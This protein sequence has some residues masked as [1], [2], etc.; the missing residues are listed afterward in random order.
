VIES[1]VRHT[2]WFS[3]GSDLGDLNNDGLMD[4][5]AADM[6]ASTHYRDKMMMGNMEDSGW[7]LDLAE[8]RQYMRNAVYVNSGADQM[9]E[10][11]FQSG[12]SSS[13]WTWSPRLEDFDNDGRVDVFATNGILRDAMNSDLSKFATTSFQPGSPEWAQF[14]AKQPMHKEA[15]QAFKNLG[16]L[17]FKQVASEWGLDRSG[18]S[19]GAATADF[20]NDGDLDLV[21]NNADTAVSLYENR[22]ATGHSV[23]VRLRGSK[24]NRFGIGATVHVEAGGQ[25]HTRYLTLSRGWLSACEPTLHVGLGAAAKI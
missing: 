13:D 17:K 2:P 18:V 10:V 8:P 20:D 5:F 11:A 15:N 25:Q 9:M 22:S 21:I 12:L 14:W 16:D 6:S 4:F 24:S 23:R 3:M 19:F 1:A 7:F